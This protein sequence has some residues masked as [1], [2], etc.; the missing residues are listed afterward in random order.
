MCAYAGFCW[1]CG[2]AA[3]TY[4]PLEGS[5]LPGLQCP[6]GY[7]CSEGT[8]IPVKCN[9]GYWCP[10]GSTNPQPCPAGGFCPVGSAKPQ[11]CPAGHYCPLNQSTAVACPAGYVGSTDRVDTCSLDTGCSLCPKGTYAN[12]PGMSKCLP[13][14]PGYVCFEGCNSA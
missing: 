14:R 10:A 4:C 11:P 3:G 12:K 9:Q 2:C 6:A 7:V 8:A 13:C 1:F 5:D